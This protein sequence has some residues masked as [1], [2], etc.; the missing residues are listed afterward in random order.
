MT[1][2]SMG[3][4]RARLDDFRNYGRMKDQLDL[5]SQL[6]HAHCRLMRHTSL[7]DAIDVMCVR[8]CVCLSMYMRNMF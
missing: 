3:G 6:L 4:W 2:V 1:R 7:A 8:A 5:F